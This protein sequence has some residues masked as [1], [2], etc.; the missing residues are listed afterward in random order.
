MI[1]LHT[2]AIIKIKLK[3]LSIKINSP[4]VITSSMNNSNYV[5]YKKNTFSRGKKETIIKRGRFYFVFGI[6][7]IYLENKCLKY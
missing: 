5:I 7:K 6:K 2:K 3:L 1:L 4:T